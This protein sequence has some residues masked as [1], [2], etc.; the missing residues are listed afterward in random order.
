VVRIGAEVDAAFASGAAPARH[1]QLCRPRALWRPLPPSVLG[2]LLDAAGQVYHEKVA[3]VVRGAPRLPK[4]VVC[5][6]GEWG[7]WRAAVAVL[8]AQITLLQQAV[9]W[10]CPPWQVQCLWRTLMPP[11]AVWVLWTLRHPA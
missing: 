1:P 4:V 5:S 2:G 8:C 7:A 9:L 11:R 6:T 10:P 3:A